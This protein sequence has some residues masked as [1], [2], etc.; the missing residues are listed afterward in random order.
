MSEAVQGFGSIVPRQQSYEGSS[1]RRRRTPDDSRLDVERSLAE[2]FDLLR[3]CDPDRF[4]AFME[5]RGA[6]Y[7]V[8]LKRLAAEGAITN[9]PRA[10]EPTNESKD[11][12]K[13]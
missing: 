2:Q 7:S 1:S 9:E 4:P 5:Y 10:N 3:V 6:R 12:D 11:G 13:A 8:T